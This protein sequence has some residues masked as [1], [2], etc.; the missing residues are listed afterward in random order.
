M[1]IE[2]MIFPVISLIV[3]SAVIL[4]EIQASR[5]G[6]TAQI[7]H[8]TSLNAIDESIGRAVEMG[9]P[10]HFSAGVGNLTV[11]GA[12]VT[13]ASLSFL[14]HIA[15]TCA[16][17][18]CKLV[19][20]VAQGDVYAASDEIMKQAY[21]R[22]GKPEMYTPDMLR[23]LSVIQYVY[24]GGVVGT[25]NREKASANFMIGHYA[26]EALFIAEEAHQAGCVQVAGTTNEYQI[27]FF[28]AACDYV[29]IGE[30]IFAAAAQLSGD[31]SELGAI[32][33]QDFAKVL[34]IGL[35]I[36]GSI[37]ATFNIDFLIKLMSK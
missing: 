6:K 33:G 32:T 22:A 30:E 24:A 13:L 21:L 18:D 14:S 5:R 9:R 37:L 29:L 11:R 19:V 31:Q 10:V 28:V 27:P 36:A 12:P 25:I 2:G 34:A 20:T 8:L 3:L 1:I 26:N 7:R 35:C 16:R 15:E 23:F 4:M 17:Y